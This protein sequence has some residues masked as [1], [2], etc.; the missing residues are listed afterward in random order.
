[1]S[2]SDVEAYLGTPDVV[3]SSRRPRWELTLPCGSGLDF[4]TMFYWPGQEY[5]DRIWGDP[6]ERIGEWL[7]VHE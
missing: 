1:M 5:P 4:D 3:R 2:A 6:A 7:Y